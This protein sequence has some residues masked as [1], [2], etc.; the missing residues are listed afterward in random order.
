M[1]A[2]LKPFSSEP[3]REVEVKISEFMKNNEWA[4]MHDLDGRITASDQRYD[5][6]EFSFQ[7]KKKNKHIFPLRIDFSRSSKRN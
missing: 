4:T 1:V 6:S 2:L 7:N 3:I 5:F